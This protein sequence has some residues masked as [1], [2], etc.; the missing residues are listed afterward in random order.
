MYQMEVKEKQDI[1]KY[2]LMK[3]MQCARKCPDLQLTVS[4]KDRYQVQR[5]L[6]N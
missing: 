1:N 4:V 5:I 2:F 6:H 3:N